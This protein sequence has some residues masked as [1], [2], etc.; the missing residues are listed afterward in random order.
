MTAQEE[1]GE[2][3][4]VLSRSPRGSGDELCVCPATATE[5]GVQGEATRAGEAG[6]ATALEAGMRGQY[7]YIGLG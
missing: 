2:E 4:A 1:E 6:A 3:S 7:N 5:T